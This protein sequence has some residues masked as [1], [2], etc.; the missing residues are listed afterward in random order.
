MR[1]SARRLVQLGCIFLLL[2][3]QQVALTHAIWHA[4][5]GN[6]SDVTTP[7]AAHPDHG[8]PGVSTVCAFDAAFGQV[9]GAV[10]GGGSVSVPRVSAPET[11]LQSFRALASRDFLHPLSRGP[12][13][14]LHA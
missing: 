5:G 2:F 11:P 3:A 4:H 8:R 6:S 10:S 13:P 14:L 7:V 12:P 9:L 1:S